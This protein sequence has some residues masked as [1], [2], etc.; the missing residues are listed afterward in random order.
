MDNDLK[1][2][3]QNYV[4]SCAPVQWVAWWG[5]VT[6]PLAKQ[7]LYDILFDAETDSLRDLTQPHIGEEMSALV[8]GSDYLRE[9]VL[10][11][12]RPHLEKLASEEESDDG[13]TA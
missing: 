3:L 2:F 12:A 5:N 8:L 1:R 9:L 10:S 7:Q 6:D 11:E 13:Y 4:R